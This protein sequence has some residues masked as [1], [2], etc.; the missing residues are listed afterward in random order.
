MGIQIPHFDQFAK[1]TCTQKFSVLQFI[2][3]GYMSKY[4]TAYCGM[5]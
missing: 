2:G 4:I 5:Q 3:L 1:I